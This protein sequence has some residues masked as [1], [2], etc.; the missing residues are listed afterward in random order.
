MD[1]DHHDDDESTDTE[2]SDEDYEAVIATLNATT[3]VIRTACTFLQQIQ[4][5]KKL[6]SDDNGSNKRGGSRKGKAWNKDRD[7]QFAYDELI[8]NYFSGDDSV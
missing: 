5:V 2:S 3:A 1:S 7:F 6:S 4:E 8:K